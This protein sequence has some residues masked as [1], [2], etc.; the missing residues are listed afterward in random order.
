M[1]PDE[2]SSVNAIGHG[3]INPGSVNAQIH[4]SEIESGVTI[5]T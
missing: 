4:F 1:K 2:V 5:E 3:F